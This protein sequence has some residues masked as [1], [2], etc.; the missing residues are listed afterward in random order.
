MNLRKVLLWLMF[1]VALAVIAY[2][3]P[4]PDR[5]TD[6]PVYEATAQHFVVPDCADLHCF[7]VL[8]PWVLGFATGAVVAEVEDLR[9]AGQCNRG[10]RRPRLVAGVGAAA[11]RRGDGGDDVGVWLRSAVYAA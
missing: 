5:V 2:L 6:R 10:D 7:R 4:E 8:M 3:S 9:G 11:S 1:V